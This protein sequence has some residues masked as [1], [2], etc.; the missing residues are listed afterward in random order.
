MSYTKPL[1]SEMPEMQSYMWKSQ[2]EY[3][4]MDI[5]E[6]VQRYEHMRRELGILFSRLKMLLEKGLI[7][8]ISINEIL[9]QKIIFEERRAE[10]EEKHRGKVVVVCNGEVFVGET[11]D[12]AVAKAKEKHGNRPYYSEALGITDFPSVLF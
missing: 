4:H 9:E 2:P 1:M 5:P 11:I 6:S 10:L 12:D 7:D 3:V 8:E